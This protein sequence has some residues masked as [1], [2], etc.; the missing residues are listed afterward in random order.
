MNAFQSL[1][2]AKTPYHMGVKPTHM[3]LQLWKV[4]T[5]PPAILHS[6]ANAVPR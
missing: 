5:V 1:S 6:L 4:I 2:D 3:I